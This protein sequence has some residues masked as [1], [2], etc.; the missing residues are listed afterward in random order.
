MKAYR[1]IESVSSD[2]D[3]DDDDGMAKESLANIYL[4]SGMFMA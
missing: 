2:G 1:Y 3:G 4:F